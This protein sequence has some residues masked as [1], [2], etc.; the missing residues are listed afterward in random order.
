M[1]A[2][3]I[4][5]AIVGAGP[6]GLTAALFLGRQGIP[7][8]IFERESE[9]F[10]DPRAAT[11]HPPTLEMYEPVGITRRLHAA[12]IIAPKWHYRDRRGGVIAEFDLSILA[13]E[14]RFP[15][16]LQCEQH[17]LC[18]MLRETLADYPSVTLRYSMP[19]KDVRQDAEGVD[20]VVGPEDEVR[21]ATYVIGADG[22]RSVVRKSQAIEFV[23]FTYLA[24]KLGLGEKPEGA[25]WTGIYGVSLL[26][27]I[28]FTMS[29]FIGTL[30][31]DDGSHAAE[32]RLGVLVGS[33]L[34]AVAGIAVL[35]WDR[36]RQ[37]K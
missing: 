5:V 6:S 18:R 29:L 25:G 36:R 34:S 13:G 22:G 19:V 24:V 9:I 7:V 21:R 37:A 16:R 4:P 31:W 32:I 10:E 14:T 11:F 1:A 8:T 23:G 2:E 28:G 17:K 33:I 15:Y 20:L 26:A 12:G 30:A 3:P 35:S 27:G